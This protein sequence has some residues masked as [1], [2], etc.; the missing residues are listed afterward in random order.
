MMEV[1]ATKIPL[2]EQITRN[3]ILQLIST[4][5]TES[6]HYNIDHIS[7]NGIDEYFE[8]KYNSTSLSILSTQL[9]NKT[10]LATRFENIEESNVWETDC[11]YC[12][13]IEDETNKI[14]KSFFITLS[15]SSH[16]FS[17]SLPYQ[18]KPH[19]IKMLFDKNYCDDSG[20]FPITNQAIFVNIDNV[21]L[22]AKVFNGD[23]AFE[24][25]L[26]YISY[27][28]AIKNHYAVDYNYLAKELSGIA[29]VLVETDRSI[30]Q[31]L[32]GFTN[33]TNIYGGYV[34]IYF[35]GNK[36]KETIS[37]YDF[38]HDKR[39]Y[40]KECA[41]AIIAKLNKAIL[42]NNSFSLSWAKLSAD[43]HRKILLAKQNDQTDPSLEEYIQCFDAENERLKGEISALRDE[44]NRKNSIIELLQKKNDPSS[45]VVL[46]I[47]N[48]EEFFIDEIK[49][50][51]L[52]ILHCAQKKIPT[53]TR[54]YDILSAILN[55]N[56]KSNIGTELFNSI[57]KALSEPLP[58]R[59]KSLD[60]CGFTVTAGSHDKIIFHENKYV[61]SLSNS[62]S[63][64]RDTINFYQDIMKRINVY[65]DLF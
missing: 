62:P 53:D 36:T 56:S 4:W 3:D 44:L 54:S 55:N 14:T 45:S 16:D 41:N 10:I 51:I 23:I 39:L 57:K 34:G 40:R 30:S 19:I 32:Q 21:E 52:S 46:Q 12:E 15:C 37:F 6:P 65:K 49:D 64:Y 60:R 35:P 11:I 47:G 24:L 26:I 48:L 29:V 28:K 58:Q 2:K 17:D 61:F 8:E 59:R 18:H 5:L 1:F 22:C 33:G 50:C 25:P 42:Y 20:C 38:I 63:D 31:K 27:N 9:D 13:E 43:Y 7:Y